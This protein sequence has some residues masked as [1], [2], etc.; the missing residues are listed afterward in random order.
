M[1]VASYGGWITIQTTLEVY[2]HLAIFLHTRLAM[3]NQWPSWPPPCLVKFPFLASQ[4]SI[5][6]LGTWST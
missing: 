5:C 2:K 4:A 1:E 3:H 6:N